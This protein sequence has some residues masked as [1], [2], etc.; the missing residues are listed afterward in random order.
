MC[1][2]C[3]LPCDIFDVENFIGY[4]PG[5]IQSPHLGADTPKLGTR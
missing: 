5:G 3:M 1:F 4:G 2:Y